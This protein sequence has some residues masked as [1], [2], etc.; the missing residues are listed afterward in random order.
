MQARDIRRERQ[1]ERRRERDA[2]EAA[3]RNRPER[4]RRR[5]RWRKFWNGL[6]HTAGPLLTRVLAWTWRIERQGEP[7]M[8]VAYGDRP[9]VLA[10]WH[11]RLVPPLPIKGHA[12]RGLGILVSPSDDGKLAGIA[13]RSFG[14]RVILGSASRGGASALREMSEA[15]QEGTP[16]IITPDG[17]RGP[18]HAMNSGPAWLARGTQVPMLGLGIAVNRCWRLKSWDRLVVPKPF[19]KI[20]LRFTDPVQVAADTTDLQLEE[21]AGTLG[22]DLLAAERQGFATLGIA[23]DHDA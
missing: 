16:V 12:H 3:G 10:L 4:S 18:R 11:G 15:L 8:A 2:R 20:V 21:L 23:D 14:Y 1:D 7:G 19:A 17:P 22:R 13:L 9:F 6:L 5:R